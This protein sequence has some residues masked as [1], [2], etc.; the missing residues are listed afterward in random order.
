M[1]C[2]FADMAEEEIKLQLFNGTK[3]QAV[4]KEVLAANDKDSVE[5]ILDRVRESALI[6][7]SIRA[8][9]KTLVLN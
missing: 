6:A 9:E 7:S 2:G 8:T 1:P 5:D 3:D 4:R